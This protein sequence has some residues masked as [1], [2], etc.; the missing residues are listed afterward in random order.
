MENVDNYQFCQSQF[1]TESFDILQKIELDARNV[2][3]C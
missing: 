3:H 2:F 1:Y